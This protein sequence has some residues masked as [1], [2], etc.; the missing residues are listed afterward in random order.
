MRN[1]IKL[2][3]A[4]SLFL[5]IVNANVFAQ[6]DTL[7][8]VSTIDALLN[9]IY[10]GETAISE[11]KQRG[12]FGIG[13]FN[14]LDG[15][16]FAIDGRFY[17]INADGKAR[18]AD[19]NIKTPF[20]AVTFFETDQGLALKSGVDFDSLKKQMDKVIPT[21][22]I[23][24]AIRI[25]GVFKA[26]KARSV[27]KQSKPYKLPKEIVKTQPIFNYENVEGTIGGF[28]CPPYVKGINV[29]GYHFHFLTKDGKAGG[30]VLE[31]TIQEAVVKI[32]YTSMFSIILP[33]DKAFYGTDLT[34]D[35]GAEL[36]KVER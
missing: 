24:Y 5:H 9:G 4:V 29:P 25:E 28:R 11:L 30:H 15:E 26:V 10:D 7:T 8:Q 21:P 14:A 22:N 23:F 34:R 2:F 33:Q 18:L 1:F 32:D 35:K 17:Q 3:F 19:N 20:A 16:M 36:K 12:N 27:P 13:T 6:G 31:F